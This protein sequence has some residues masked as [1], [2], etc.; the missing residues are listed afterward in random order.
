MPLALPN[1]F[2]KLCSKLWSFLKIMLLF[3]KVCF[4]KNTQ[5][6]SQNHIF[7]EH[8]IVFILSY[9]LARSNKTQV[10]TALHSRLKAVTKCVKMY[11]V[12]ITFNMFWYQWTRL[13]V[14]LSLKQQ[15]M[16]EPVALNENG[17]NHGQNLTEIINFRDQTSHD[18]GNVSLKKN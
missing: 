4:S 12:S 16:A 2:S 15:K 10:T 17:L 7:I 11:Y 6:K 1:I 8:D 3:L 14:K 18:P 5:D 9:T 13:R